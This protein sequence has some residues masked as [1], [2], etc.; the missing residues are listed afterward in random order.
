MGHFETP[1]FTMSQTK[2]MNQHG[3]G[4]IQVWIACLQRHICGLKG[5][6]TALLCLDFLMEGIHFLLKLFE[7]QICVTCTIVLGRKAFKCCLFSSL[8]NKA[9]NHTYLKMSTCLFCCLALCSPKFLVLSD[10]DALYWIDFFP[11]IPHT[12]SDF[13]VLVNSAAFE[14]F[15]QTDFLFLLSWNSLVPVLWL[16]LLHEI[17]VLP[18]KF[19]KWPKWGS[20]FPSFLVVNQDTKPQRFYCATK[21]DQ[22]YLWKCH[23]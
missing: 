12:S 4:R 14:Y 9:L 16:L 20:L 23:W 7:A 19:V 22:I 18:C 8:F 10:W 13:Q 5:K 11:F 17:T 2:L 3:K 1:C 6:F 21:L 15:H